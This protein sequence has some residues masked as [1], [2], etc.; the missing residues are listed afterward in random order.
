[1]GDFGLGKPGVIAHDEHGALAIRQGGDSVTELGRE[2]LDRVGS[3][4]Q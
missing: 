1:V 4:Q 2:E 3:V